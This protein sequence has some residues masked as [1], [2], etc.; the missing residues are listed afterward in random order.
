MLMTGLALQVTGLLLLSGL[1]PTWGAALSVAWVVTAQGIAGVAK[2]I[3]KTAS[4]S[5]IK[6]ASE[7]GFGQLLKWVAW[8]TG[9]KNAM[10]GAG[11]FVGGLCAARYRALATRVMDEQTRVGLLELAEKYE[12]LARELQAD[13][14]NP[15]DSG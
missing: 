9:S 15:R 1:E 11:C 7:G 6:A 4:K 13:D 3:A 5:A 14:P 2:D 10:N 8:F 12:T